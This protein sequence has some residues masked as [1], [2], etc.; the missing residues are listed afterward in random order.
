M[1]LLPNPRKLEKQV[2]RATNGAVFAV[3]FLIFGA[4][5]ATAIFPTMWR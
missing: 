4:W 2:N 5:L 1:E 3:L